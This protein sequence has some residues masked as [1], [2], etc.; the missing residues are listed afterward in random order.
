MASNNSPK[1]TR[2]AALSEMLDLPASIAQKPVESAR[3]RRA[4]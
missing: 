3:L 4:A 1:L 2:R